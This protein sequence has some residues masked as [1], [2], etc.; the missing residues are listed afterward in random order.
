MFIEIFKKEVWERGS[1]YPSTGTG[2]E[3]S[4]RVVS[5]L[6]CQL[7]DCYKKIMKIS[8]L[9]VMGYTIAMNL[10][11]MGKGCKFPKFNV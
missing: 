5:T 3:L 10:N 1:F 11:S 7:C 8:L 9:Y 4:F 6:K 2:N